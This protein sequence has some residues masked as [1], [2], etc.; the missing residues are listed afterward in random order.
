MEEN[1]RRHQKSIFYQYF[2]ES[3]SPKS[4]YFQHFNSIFLQCVCQYI[5]QLCI[6][7]WQWQLQWQWSRQ[8]VRGSAAVWQ[9]GYVAL[10]V[11]Q[12]WQ[13]WQRGSG[14][15]LFLCPFLNKLVGLIL[16]QSADLGARR[17]SERLNVKKRRQANDTATVAV[18]AQPHTATASTTASATATASLTASA[19]ASATLGA[20]CAGTATATATA[21][22]RVGMDAFFRILGGLGL[23]FTVFFFFFLRNLGYFGWNLSNFG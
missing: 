13:W 22:V 11:W 10:A 4:R 8:C 15:Q 14:T 21:T 9:C 6:C 7:V 1:G 5:I 16:T 18:A 17:N 12:W 23:D 19:T 3:S 20:R 2:F